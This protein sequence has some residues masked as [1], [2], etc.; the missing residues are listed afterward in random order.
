MSNPHPYSLGD[1]GGG[2]GGQGGGP[3]AQ[4][5]GPGTQG[6]RNGL[7][8]GDLNG[9]NIGGCIIALLE[10]TVPKLLSFTGVIV[11]SVNGLKRPIWLD[12]V[13]LSV[14]SEAAYAALLSPTIT[15]KANVPN[16]ILE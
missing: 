9:I 14:L 2:P 13:L 16:T 6:G 1:Q 11:I 12:V 5:G 15:T 7:R 8:G 3:G 10:I 4:G